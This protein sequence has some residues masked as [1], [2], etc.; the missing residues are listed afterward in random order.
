MG[1]P[2]EPTLTT[3]EP[4]ALPP[5]PSPHLG[6]AF[7][8]PGR[9]RGGLDRDHLEGVRLSVLVS[10]RD[11]FARHEG[12][13]CKPKARLLVLFGGALVIKNPTGMFRA[14]GTMDQEPDLIAF[15]L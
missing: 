12:V 5:A 14:P 13:G 1:A 11:I 6:A 4:P 2:D 7:I 10:D 15:A 3:R 8:P 9:S